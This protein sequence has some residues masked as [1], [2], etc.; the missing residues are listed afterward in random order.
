MKIL[1]TIGLVLAGLVGVVV[2]VTVALIVSGWNTANGTVGNPV[3]TLLVAPDSS[4]VP[5]GEHL[6]RVVC[7]GCHSTNI[8]PPLSGGDEDFL[9]GGETPPFGHLRAPNITP[10][11]RLAAYSDGELSRAIR[12]GVSREGRPMLVMPSAGFHE[13]S[14]RDL[15]ALIAYLRSQPAV[16]RDVPPRQIS[17]LGCLILGL[18]LFETSHMRPAGEAKHGAPEGMTAE[19]GAYLVPMLDCATC[20]G[21]DLRGAKPGQFPPHGP[22]LVTLASTHDLGQFDQALRHGTSTRDG[23]T[24]DPK[25]MPYP[26]Y[27]NLTDTEVGAIYAHLQRLREKH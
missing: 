15:A 25:R 18:H 21:A 4:L 1:R 17:P 3:P 10:G 5:R 13:M 12:E 23:H 27:A 24:L 16:H 14:D 19:Y 26:L 9:G 2:V 6:A 22:D 11:G 20:H 7:A 8:Q